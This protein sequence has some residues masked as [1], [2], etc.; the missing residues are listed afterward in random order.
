[1]DENVN[2]DESKSTSRTKTDKIKSPASKSSTSVAAPVKDNK[3]S[4]PKK[5]H[6]MFGVCFI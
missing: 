1:M 3:T 5:M 2:A 6:P 4:E